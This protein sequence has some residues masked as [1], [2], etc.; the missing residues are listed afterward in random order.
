MSALR[1]MY[2]ASMST[3]QQ[4]ELLAHAQ[5]GSLQARN[6]LLVSIQPRLYSLAQRFLRQPIKWQEQFVEP[7]DLVNTANVVLLRWFTR[8]LAHDDPLAYLLTAARTAML[9]YLSGKQ[10][11]IKTHSY[12]RPYN[13]VSLD[14]YSDEV[15]LLCA[16]YSP[17]EEMCWDHTASPTQKYEELYQ[18]I[19]QLPSKQ[20]EVIL[21]QFGLHGH[22]PESV[23][24][25][26]RSFSAQK[27]S[28]RPRN[29]GYYKQRALLA[30]RQAL[31][32]NFLQPEMDQS[33][34]ENNER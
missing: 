4:Q 29:A 5:T 32:S 31:S 2:P 28:S 26:G 27:T 1:R 13:I 6:E 20:R 11:F 12:Q 10:G 24:A 18:A 16:D 25:I 7:M 19:E 9:D 33:S 34:E 21:R 14:T 22:Q 30:L 15:D 17:L 3:S 23:Y 8:A